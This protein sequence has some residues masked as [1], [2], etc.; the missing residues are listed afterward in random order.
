MPYGRGYGGR[1]DHLTGGTG[2]TNP[3]TFGISV[4]QGG[5]DNNQETEVPVPVLR[6]GM[7]MTRAQVIEVT[8][9]EFELPP[10]KVSEADLLLL[11]DVSLTSRSIG[12]NVATLA[13]PN[14]LAKYSRRINYQ[15]VGTGANLTVPI[16]NQVV[17]LDLTDGAGH[18]LLV[19]SANLYFQVNSVGT[20]IDGIFAFR[21][22]YRFKQIGA[23]A[24]AASAI[25]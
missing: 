5:I 8:R 6:M 14:L 15:L 22:F 9:V 1:R 18:G 12:P 24:F 16:H 7:S 2:D 23:R 10:P 25:N 13:D 19:T 17:S 3:Q 20:G 11:Y 4:T 21:V